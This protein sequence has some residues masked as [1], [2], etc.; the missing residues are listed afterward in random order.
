MLLVVAVDQAEHLAHE[1]GAQVKGEGVQ[2]GE[3]GKGVRVGGGGGFGV[4]SKY[5]GGASG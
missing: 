4:R 5:G 2:G 3:G 1:G